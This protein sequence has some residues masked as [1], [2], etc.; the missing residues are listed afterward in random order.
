MAAPEYVPTT[1]ATK[2]RAYASPPRRPASWQPGRPSEIA[3]LQP[4]G[5]RLG[6]Q[7]PDQ[8]YALK[9]AEDHLADQ[10]QL[11][12]GEHTRDAVA[13]IVAVGLKRASLFKRAPVLQ[14]LRIAATIFGFLDAAPSSDLLAMRT[15]LFEEVGHFHHYAELREIADLVSEDTLRKLPAE[16]AAA[17]DSDWRSLLDLG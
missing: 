2:V 17:H 10:L 12:T 1:P 11:K 16:I 13:G 15:K 14:D 9:L 8:G 5:D 4:E 6:M 7:G 3:Q